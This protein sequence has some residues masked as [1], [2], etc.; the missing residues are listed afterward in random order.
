MCRNAFRKDSVS[1]PIV[2]KCLREGTLFI[3]PHGF[4]NLI[5]SQAK[6]AL[7]PLHSTFT[8]GIPQHWGGGGGAPH[9]RWGDW[10]NL[11]LQWELCCLLERPQGGSQCFEKPPHPTCSVA[12]L[13]QFSYSRLKNHNASRNLHI[14]HAPPVA[15]VIPSTLIQFSHCWIDCKTKMFRETSTSHMLLLLQP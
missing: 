7:Q 4:V 9:S 3:S 1:I 10:R 14:P 15:T 5:F 2:L 12:T 8:I 6:I 13:I 11:L